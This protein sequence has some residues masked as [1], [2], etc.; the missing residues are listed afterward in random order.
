MTI[1][2]DA[3][4]ALALPRG[5]FLGAATSAYQIEGAVDVDGRGVSIWD[6]FCAQRGAIADGSSGQMAC[7]HY[8][9]W[10]ED[11]ALMQ[12]LGLQAYRFSIA[13]PRVS[14]TARARGIS[15]DYPSTSV[16]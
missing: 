4:R 6:R 11:V 13:W 16:W 2:R 1:D 3:I 12:Q 10:E 15:G 5:F 14:P 7:D 8:R 9:R